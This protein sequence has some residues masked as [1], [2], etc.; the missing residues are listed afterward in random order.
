M[1]DGSRLWVTAEDN[2]LRSINTET[3]TFSEPIRVG[4]SPVAIAFD[5]MRLWVAN[6]SDMA[7]QAIEPAAAFIGEPV[8]LWTALQGR[9]GSSSVTAMA[10][11]G[12][13]LHFAK[14]GGLLSLD[15]SDPTFMSFGWIVTQSYCVSALIPVDSKLWFT[16]GC[17]NSVRA[18]DFEGRNVS[19]PIMVGERPDH[20]IFD[21]KRLWVANY[22]S[23]SVQAVDVTGG[24]A[25]PAIP[26]SENPSSLAFD[27][28]R[29]WVITAQ[30]LQSIDPEKREIISSIDYFGGSGD[31]LN[32]YGKP[33]DMTF[34][35]GKLWIVT[36]ESEMHAVDPETQ[37]V[38]ARVRLG[39]GP[40]ILAFDG[41]LLWV[42]NRE[43]NTLR[44]VDTR[45]LSVG[46][47]VGIGANPA[48]MTFDGQRLWI[49][50][51]NSNVLQP[52]TIK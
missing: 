27:G 37:K 10:V 52:V 25:Y 24:V 35:A 15:T 14:G 18:I 48:S 17:Q 32:I 39:E 51:E 12:K 50:Y 28:K 16:D 7:V 31:P 41:N 2:T 20:M 38:V 30:K 49:S 44:A 13:S 36:Q 34:A 4:A 42:A 5:G 11:S 22:S 43:K 26:V 23:D 46:V 21:G 1:F 8:N 45:S 19:Q 40:K 3:H 9:F 29:L 33:S 6:Q 47:S